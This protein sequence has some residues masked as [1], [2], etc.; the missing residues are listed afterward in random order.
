MFTTPQRASLYQQRISGCLQR[1]SQPEY[2]LQEVSCLPGMTVVGLQ[3]GC[4]VTGHKSWCVGSKLK[5]SVKC[6]MA[7]GTAF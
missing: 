1:V 4:V 3:V 2:D 6:Q 5:E 7:K